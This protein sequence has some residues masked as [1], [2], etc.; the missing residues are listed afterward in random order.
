MVSAI[1][2]GALPLVPADPSPA[3]TKIWKMAEAAKAARAADTE[4]NFR[5]KRRILLIKSDGRERTETS[6]TRGN[7][8]W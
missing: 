2:E 6:N 8:C 3:S 1:L 5:G 7:R 4:T